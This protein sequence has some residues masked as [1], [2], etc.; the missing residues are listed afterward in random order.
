MNIL[1]SM[2][3][4]IAAVKDPERDFTE[5]IFLI[6]TFASEIM[7]FIAFLGDVFFKEDPVEILI[8][9][10][11]MVLIPA[12]V[13]TC[14]RLNRLKI[15]IKI[16]VIGLVT[17]ILPSIF[18]FGGGLEGGG[19][20]WIIFAF[21]YVGLVLSGRWRN[22]I[23]IL[24]ALL[25]LGCY[26]AAYEYPELVYQHSRQMYYVDSF[27]SLVLVGVLCFIMTWSQGRIFK[28]ENER[29]K[30]AAEKAE[31]LTRSQNRFFSSMSHEIRTPINSILGLNELILRDQSASDEIV[32]DASGIQGSGKM[33]LAL[34]NDILDF[35]KIEAG[36]M[37]I[38]PVDYRIGDMLSEIVNMM[39]LRAHDKG[40]GFE[41]SIDPE[42]PA[43]M[44]GDE[45]RI[46]QVIINLLNNAVK[47]TAKGHVGLR[48]E[49]KN[50][51]E[52][53]E[54]LSISV[55]DTGMGIKKDDLPYLFDAFKRVDEGKNRHIEGTG[56]GLSIV[57]QLVDLMHGTVSV[58]SV[59]GEGTTFT[60]VIDQHISDHSS[61]G[62]LN[63]H[64]QQTA[65]RSMYESSFFAPEARILIVDDNEM[66]LEVESRL[67]METDMVIDTAKSGKEALNACLKAHYDAI[68]MDHLMPEMDG[69]E[70][71]EALK[72][73][74]GG[75][76]RNTPVIV[77]T[78][79]AGSENRELYNKAGFD[80]YLVKPVSGEAMEEMLIK[81]ISSEKVLLRNSLMDDETDINTSDRYTEKIPVIITA[82]SMCDLPDA[83]RDKLG[84]PVIPFEIRTNE[85]VFKD[86]V[87]I[88]AYEL[89]RYIS[90]GHDA[91]SDVPSEADYTEFFAETL[92]KAHHIIHIAITA[93]MSRE[94][95]IASE[96]ARS[97]DNVSVIN[98]ECISSATGILVLI[99]SR[100]VQQGM[101]AEDI[102]QELEAVKQRVKC[103]FVIDT[104]EYMAKRGLLSQGLH[105]IAQT[106][107]LHPALRIRND[108]AGLGG[109]WQGRIKRVYKKYIGSA[110]PPDTIPDADVVFVTYV[111]IPMST[112]SWIEEEIRKN[113]YFEHVVFQQASAAIS[114]NCGP[115]TFGILYFLKSN[116]SYNLAAYFEE[117]EAR[118]R[119]MERYEAEEETEE[120]DIDE[121]AE[122]E[123]EESYGETAAYEPEEI[124]E[125]TEPEWYDGISFIDI[126]AGLKNSGSDDAF[127]TVLKIFH[128]SI[129]AKYG[130]L[131]DCYER[132]DWK[133]YTVKIHALKSSARLVG[134]LE[135]G[136]K[137]E[138]LEAA[139]KEE[140]IQYI[141]DNH[142]KVMEDYL[143]FEEKLAPYFAEEKE[144]GD[145][146]VN[147][148]PADEAMM[149]DVY[150][151][152]REAAEAMDC[153]MLED[154]INEIGA[155][156]IPEAEKERF[157]TVRQKADLYDYDGIL[158]VLSDVR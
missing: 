103:S 130:E 24:I 43:V 117:I 147:K 13:L 131:S 7:L 78:A 27:I 1:K 44:Y 64:S 79:N 4:A 3:A 71:L 77:L 39:W 62:E 58:N 72:N 129:P 23:F 37:D 149:K 33:L 101:Q 5:R 10:A 35:S 121:E 111:D 48:I 55:I 118:E 70:C 91:V 11:T 108:K 138:K 153:D 69:V 50:K 31:E 53:T 110:L 144:A 26:F 19:V 150:E 142:E 113:A 8:L 51:D 143:G 60:V 127:Q 100:L 67:L 90:S 2:R 154:I 134:A 124:P 59:Y 73:Q 86:G 12:I 135:L 141:R 54:E 157:E 83:V 52:D 17:V 84:I 99:A 119:A 148:P 80:G 123:T 32:R 145:E 30:K 106:L 122:A 120:Q 156:A 152:M 41:V 16:I 22:T 158:E 81:H 49:G 85:G 20:I 46:K 95:E 15:A 29:A 82:S 87:H 93:S 132:E 105:R 107:N 155:Y 88:D 89:S 133:N 18:F 65:A 114:S 139:G 57:K 112:L 34:I 96:A 68:L 25:T 126:K 45:V 40:L 151:G 92:K 125:E 75:L 66:N 47:Y 6:L 97:F 104:T 42:V 146:A 21:M 115:G 98:S 14:L 140:D 94:Y 137:A 74:A 61:V 109:I 128:D 102:V 56:L 136:D 63:I 76:N 116:K 38:V 36:S 9:I 28:E